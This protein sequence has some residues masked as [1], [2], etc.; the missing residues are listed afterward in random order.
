MGATGVKAGNVPTDRVGPLIKE[1]VEERWPEWR[2]GFEE[3]GGL[4]ILAE[5]IGCTP[6]AIDNII[7]QA[8][9]GAQFNL[10]DR[11]FCA[12]GRPDLWWGVLND[13]YLAVDFRSPLEIKREYERKRA[14]DPQVKAR[15]AERKRRYLAKMRQDPN[16]VAAE[17]ERNRQYRLRVK[18]AA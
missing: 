13:V 12:L 15:K 7:R 14:A 18:A 3:P 1:L 16:W 5:K 9:P 11:I 17:R 6:D 10:V 8:W 2:R 4:E